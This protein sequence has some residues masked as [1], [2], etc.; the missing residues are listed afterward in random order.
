MQKTIKTLQNLSSHFFALHWPNNIHFSPPLEWSEWDFNDGVPNSD[1]PGCYA[2]LNDKDE[3]IYIGVGAG[4]GSGLYQG[5]GLGS[6][7]RGSWQVSKNKA[8]KN[9]YEFVDRWTE[10]GASI[11]ITLGIDHAFGYLAYALEVFLIQNMS[12]KINVTNA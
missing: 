6:R 7:I 8:N 4:K 9:K 3:I 10:K 11:L 2:I 12:P 5:F 1:K